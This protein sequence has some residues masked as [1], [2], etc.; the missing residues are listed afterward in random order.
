M[1]T[2]T[3]GS[4]RHFMLLKRRLEQIAV[5]T[6]KVM[7]DRMR[8]RIINI[9]DLAPYKDLPP[10][11]LPGCRALAAPGPPQ[12]HGSSQGRRCRQGSSS[13]TQP[14]PG[15]RTHSSAP[16]RSLKSR[17]LQSI[18]EACCLPLFLLINFSKMHCQSSPQNS[19]CRW[20]NPN[21]LPFV[22]EPTWPLAESN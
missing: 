2:A 20:A 11:L 15:A 3:P 7:E 12:A 6:N 1:P 14:V 22:C 4:E 19:R 10:C 17:K 9:E 16:G 8:A 5:F 21:G 18:L 13:G